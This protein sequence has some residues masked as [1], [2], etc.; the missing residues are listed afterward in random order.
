VMTDAERLLPYV[1][2]GIQD[3][4]G[5]PTRTRVLKVIYLIDV[6]HYRRHGRTLT[7]WQWVFHYFGPY[8]FEY[9]KLLDSLSI[10]LIEEQQGLTHD[11]RQFYRYSVVVDQEL[12]DIVTYG[13]RVVID[14]II[15]RWALE[16]LNL[17][18]NHVYFRTEPMIDAAPGE[19]LDFRKIRR[20]G[21]TLHLHASDI[22]I[23]AQH[24]EQ[25]RQRLVESRLQRHARTERMASMLPKQSPEADRLYR[26]AMESRDSEES[27]PIP[28]GLRVDVE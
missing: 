26:D 5:T 1:I 12:G 15:S 7:G 6:E 21:P 8:A 11:G 18:L 17:L 3:Q 19:P 4:E 2:Q 28:D 23:E 27:Q 14:D 22:L 13:E 10:P 20:E 9:Q 25:F 16:D 24:R